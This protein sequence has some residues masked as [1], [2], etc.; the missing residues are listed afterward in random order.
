MAN[1][2]SHGPKSTQTTDSKSEKT[3][4]AKPANP[5]KE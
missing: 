2:G 4:A 5:P 3:S 1:G